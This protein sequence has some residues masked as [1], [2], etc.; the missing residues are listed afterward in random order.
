MG[1][2]GLTEVLKGK[3]GQQGWGKLIGC[4]PSTPERNKRNDGSG[5][6]CRNIG[7]L[8]TDQYW[9]KTE[10]C[11]ESAPAPL[12]CRD[13]CQQTSCS[14]CLQRH[15]KPLINSVKSERSCSNCSRSAQRDSTRASD[16][17]RL[18]FSEALQTCTSRRWKSELQALG[19]APGA[20]H[21]LCS[22]KLSCKDVL[23]KRT[24]WF[25]NTSYL[26]PTQPHVADRA[27]KTKGI[28]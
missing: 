24:F 16:T 20:F 7:K 23:H 9:S 15:P 18:G 28:L 2:F 6:T 27:G 8:H 5:K 10:G 12:S 26:W 1:G 19:I 4:S 3:T 22:H 17:A 25:C 21:F 14:V 13:V 11:T